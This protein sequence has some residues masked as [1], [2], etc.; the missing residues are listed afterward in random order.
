MTVMTGISLITATLLVPYLIY[1]LC[2]PE[3]F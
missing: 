3:R 2:H 1:A